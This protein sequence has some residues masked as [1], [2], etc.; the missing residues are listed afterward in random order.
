MRLWRVFRWEDGSFAM[1]CLLVSLSNHPAS[2]FTAQNCN[3]IVYIYLLLTNQAEIHL[4]WLAIAFSCPVYSS[5]CY[6]HS[7][8]TA[9]SWQIHQPFSLKSHQLHQHEHSL[10]SVGDLSRDCCCHRCRRY[11]CCY[12]EPETLWSLNLPAEPKSRRL[13]TRLNFL[14]IIYS[15]KHH[16]LVHFFPSWLTRSPHGRKAQ[17]EAAALSRVLLH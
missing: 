12:S 13:L 10:D 16:Y 14:H 15:A 6:T 3:L 11:R 7:S 9:Q 8:I 5:C 4:P 1:L 17:L 2:P